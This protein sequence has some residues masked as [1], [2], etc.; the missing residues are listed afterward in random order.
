[1]HKKIQ[2]FS[3]IRVIGL[4]AFGIVVLLVAWSSLKALQANYELEKQKVALEQQTRLQRLEN[5]NL[6][7]RNVYFESDEYLELSA[8]RQLNKGAPGEKLYQIPRSVALSHTVDLPKTKQQIATEK[9]QDKPT[10]RKNLE[11]WRDF[12]FHIGKD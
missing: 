5:E 10:Y 3:D 9:E 6:Q 2:R 7:L 1:M 11:A 12:F 8:R 4:I